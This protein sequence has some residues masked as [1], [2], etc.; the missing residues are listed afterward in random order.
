MIVETTFIVH[1]FKAREETDR[2]EAPNLPEAAHGAAKDRGWSIAE[3]HVVG[4]HGTPQ[5]AYTGEGRTDRGERFA[6]NTREAT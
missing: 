1:G 5:R 2:R 3:S 4:A 6:F